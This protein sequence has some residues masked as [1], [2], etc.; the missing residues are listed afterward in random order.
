[1]READLL[2]QM[3]YLPGERGLSHMEPFCSTSEMLLLS[4]RYK[5]RRCRNSILIPYGHWFDN[6]GVLDAPL[7]M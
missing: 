4:D 2:L 1:M 5:Y 7:E 3:L 6:K